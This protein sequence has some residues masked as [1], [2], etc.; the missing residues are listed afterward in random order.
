MEEL[1]KC[2]ASFES[3]T[4]SVSRQNLTEEQVKA[5]ADK[6]IQTWIVGRID[7][8]D[9]SEVCGELGFFDDND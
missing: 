6:L 1:I 5:I 3:D 4:F 9:L 7:G 8:H 2:I